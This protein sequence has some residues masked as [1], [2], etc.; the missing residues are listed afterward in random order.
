MKSEFKG[1]V[2][3]YFIKCLVAFL[4]CTFTLGIA[5]PWAVCLVMR[6][7]C[8]SSTIGGKQLKFSGSGGKLFLLFIK[9]WLLSVVTFGIYGFWAGRNMIRWTV[10]NI[11]TVG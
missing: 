4:L 3:E 7:V 2:F 10:E 9:W 1:S 5:T 11:E 6:W 8:E